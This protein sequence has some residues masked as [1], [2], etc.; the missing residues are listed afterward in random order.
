[1][2]IHRQMQ[3]VLL[4]QLQTFP[5]CIL[6]GFECFGWFSFLPFF[7]LPIAVRCSNC[8][9]ETLSIRSSEEFK[10]HKC[11]WKSIFSVL[12]RVHLLKSVK[13]HE[14]NEK[15]F[16]RLCFV[17]FFCFWNTFILKKKRE[18]ESKSYKRTV[19]YSDFFA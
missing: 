11:V 15:Y 8:A 3:C 7:F 10:V 14:N 2:R 4:L 18:K 9:W 1:M 5:L 12:S 13:R 19:I 16:L 6:F 17:V